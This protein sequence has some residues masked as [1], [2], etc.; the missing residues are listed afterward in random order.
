MKYYSIID[1][2]SNSIRL[3]IYTQK[4]GGEL[5]EVENVKFDARLRVYLDDNHILS[6]EGIAL[7]IQVLKGFKEIIAHYPLT[8]FVCAATATIRQASNQE[9][10]QEVVKNETGWDLRVLNEQEEAYYGYL[11]VVNSTPLTEG[12]TIDIGGGSTE[13]TYFKNRI[14]QHSHSFPFG[15]LSLQ[16]FFQNGKGYQQNAS[17][18][19]KFLYEQ[20]SSLEWLKGRSTILV[21]IGGSARNLAQIDQNRKSYP[22][23]GLHQ[24]QMQDND[25]AQIINYLSK[26]DLES[27]QKV[28]G[29]SKDRADTILPAI[30]AIYCLYQIVEAESFMLSRKGLRDGLFYEHLTEKYKNHLFPDVLHDS[31]HKLMEE[32]NLD[33]DR[34]CHMQDLATSIFNQMLAG[35]IGTFRRRDLKMIH[36]ACSVFHL[37]SYID[38]ESSAQ[39]TFYLLANRTIDGLI[40]PDRVRLALIASFKNKTL[41]KQFIEPYKHWYLKEERKHLRLLGALLNFIYSL[42]ATKR[43]VVSDILLKDKHNQIKM[44]IDCKANHMAEQYQAEQQKRYLEKAIGKPIELIFNV[45][46]E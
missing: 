38:S 12:I 5:E 45:I 35:G 23:A 14:L 25:F 2:G 28:E 40:H 41:F 36:L 16:S 29:L 11:A 1:V 18:L 4:G 13:V 39:H 37:G 17:T 24:Y 19:R 46:P 33:A 21:G 43:K 31:M 22:L 34:A 6:E 9:E 8:Q 44:I 3:V 27:L 42:D 20:F 15:A 10:I 26:L 7:L 30:E 32:Y